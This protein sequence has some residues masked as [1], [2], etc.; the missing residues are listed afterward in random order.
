MIMENQTVDQQ[1]KN[2][3]ELYEICKIHLEQWGLY[4]S[5]LYKNFEKDELIS[6]AWV[7]GLDLSNPKFLKNRIK[8]N[9]MDY[10]RE[11]TKARVKDKIVEKTNMLH[12][13]KEGDTDSLGDLLHNIKDKELDLVDTKDLIQ[14]LL[15]NSFLDTKKHNVKKEFVRLYFMENMSY[16]EISK[17]MDISQCQISFNLTSAKK[18]LKEKMEQ[19]NLN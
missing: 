16:P 4:F 6:E 15:E 10:I 1:Q 3:E 7:R 12:N 2:N 8:F 5:K 13:K 14:Y 17:K 18:I 11:Y 9:M 19:L